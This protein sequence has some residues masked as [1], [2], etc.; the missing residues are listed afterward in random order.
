LNGNS[1]SVTK[2]CEDTNLPLEITAIL[3]FCHY[4]L[5]MSVH[6]LFGVVLGE[7]GPVNWK[8][9]QQ[10]PQKAHLCVD[11][12]IHNYKVTIYTQ[13]SMQETE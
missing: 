12:V 1:F 2:F 8:L 9:Y 11:I 13:W 5:K 10:N 4:N 6:A 7:F 3:N